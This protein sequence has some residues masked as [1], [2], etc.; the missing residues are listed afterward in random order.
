[1]KYSFL[2]VLYSKLNDPE[3]DIT[4]GKTLSIICKNPHLNC[5]TYQ[6]EYIVSSAPANRLVYLVNKGRLQI[7]FYKHFIFGIAN[8]LLST[9]LI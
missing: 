5:M 1:M 3:N 8:N 9:S 2:S 6:L 7:C 4:A